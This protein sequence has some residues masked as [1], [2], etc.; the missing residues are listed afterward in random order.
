MMALQIV[1][2]HFAEGPFSAK[3]DKLRNCMSAILLCPSHYDHCNVRLIVLT[4]G[5]S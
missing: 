3:G 4:F 2:D 5:L 1:F